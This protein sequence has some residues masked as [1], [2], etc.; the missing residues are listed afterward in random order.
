MRS[1][2]CSGG[3]RV[4]RPAVVMVLLLGV[5]CRTAPQTPTGDGA[6]APLQVSALAIDFVKNEEGRLQF[7]LDVPQGAGRTVA[8]MT[9]ELW[10]GSLRFATG[11]E[12][13][14]KGVL[15]PD[16][17]LRLQVDAPLAYRHITWV[18]GS[19]YLDV[20]FRA[21]VLFSLPSGMVSKFETHREVLG[22]GKPVADETITE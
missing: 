17:S 20:R 7:A 13:P 14:M 21:Q 9:W 19:T 3:E 4:I 11:I 8:Q 1:S 12:G 18:E 5:T 15:Q 22:H 16:G 2:R 10:V 6:V